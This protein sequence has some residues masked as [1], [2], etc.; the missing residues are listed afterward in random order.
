MVPSYRLFVPSRFLHIIHRRPKQMMA[1]AIVGVVLMLIEGIDERRFVFGAQVLGAEGYVPARVDLRMQFRFRRSAYPQTD[2]LQ[3]IPMDKIIDRSK[4]KLTLV[5][6]VRR[7][8]RYKTRRERMTEDRETVEARRMGEL[9]HQIHHRFFGACK[10]L[11][12][13]LRPNGIRYAFG[14]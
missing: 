2:T 13:C 11:G 5:H 3:H 4:I 9:I 12:T 7:C 14:G 10:G 1:D 6:P 8:R